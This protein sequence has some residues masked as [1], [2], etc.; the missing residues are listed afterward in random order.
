LTVGQFRTA[1]REEK[2]VLQVLA[3]QE[4]NRI[5]HYMPLHP[6]I[7][8]VISEVLNNDFGEKDDAKLLFM[9]N[10]LQTG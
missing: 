3:E 8:G 2:P 7:I 6:S 5:E 10:S 9:F 4:K 1:L